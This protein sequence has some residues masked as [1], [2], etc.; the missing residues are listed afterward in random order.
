MAHP[1]TL[2]ALGGR[3]PPVSGRKPV[4]GDLGRQTLGDIYLHSLMRAQLRLG[5]AVVG[6]LVAVLGG[7]PFLFLAA[8]ALRNAMVAGVPV[9]W[10]I[11]GVAVHPVILALAFV[12]L[13][14][15]RRNEDDFADLVERS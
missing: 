2:A 12:C 6:V 9:P 5:L 7:L 11:I 15:A 1:R 13:R 10:L 4:A 8:P 3:R 14:H